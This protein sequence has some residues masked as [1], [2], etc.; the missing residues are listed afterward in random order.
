MYQLRKT[1]ERVHH[2]AIGILVDL[3]Y[4]LPSQSPLEIP[5]FYNYKGFQKLNILKLYLSSVKYGFSYLA[6]L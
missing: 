4:I 2:V 6:V 3:F 1:D 5:V